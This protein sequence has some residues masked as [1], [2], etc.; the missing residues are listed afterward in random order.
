MQHGYN[1]YRQSFSGKCGGVNIPTTTVVAFNA[2]KN[3]VQSPRS[4][5]GTTSWIT[6]PLT[7]TGQTTVN[8][9]V[10]YYHYNVNGT[11]MYYYDG[12]G[13]RVYETWAVAIPAY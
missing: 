4:K 5:T 7:T 1:Q 6:V 11:N 13:S 2:W 8:V 3:N 9:H 12:T 10:E